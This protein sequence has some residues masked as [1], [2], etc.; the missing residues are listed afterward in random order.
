MRRGE[1]QKPKKSF[2]KEKWSKV[3]TATEKLIWSHKILQGFSKKEIDNF[4]ENSF[5]RVVI[6]KTPNGTGLK[7]KGNCK[8]VQWM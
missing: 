8:H 3:S 1:L 6:M 5:N 7:K 2:K 4:G